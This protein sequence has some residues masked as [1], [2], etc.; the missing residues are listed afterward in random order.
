MTRP[1]FQRGEES[2]IRIAEG[3]LSDFTRTLLGRAGYD[4]LSADAAT[5]A[6]MHGSLLG[7][8]SHGVR[9]VPHYVRVVEGGRVNGRPRFSFSGSLRAS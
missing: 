6:V 1:A 2:V 3:P 7:V 8:D 4:A 5:R 9:L